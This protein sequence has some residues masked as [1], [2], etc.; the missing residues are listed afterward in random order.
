M[1]VRDSPRGKSLAQSLGDRSVVLMRGHGDGDRG[2]ICQ[3][4]VSGPITP[5][6]MPVC[7]RKLSHW[8]VGWTSII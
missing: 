5:T 4:G 6:S 3:N 7:S 8:G 2:A 1:L